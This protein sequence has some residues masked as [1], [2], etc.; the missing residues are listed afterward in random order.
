MLD[1]VMIRQPLHRPLELVCC[2]FVIALEFAPLLDG[3]GYAAIYG[4]PDGVITRKTR[5]GRRAP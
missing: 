4:A 1:A 5:K 2:L 3:Q